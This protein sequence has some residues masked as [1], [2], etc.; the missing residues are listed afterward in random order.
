LA[1]FQDAVLAGGGNA[2]Q[3]NDS[4]LFVEVLMCDEVA[5]FHLFECFLNCLAMDDVH[6]FAKYVCG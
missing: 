6:D 4:S 2:P 3:P 1:V 5:A